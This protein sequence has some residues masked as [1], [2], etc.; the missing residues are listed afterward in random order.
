[1]HRTLVSLSKVLPRTAVPKQSVVASALPSLNRSRQPNVLD[2]LEQQKV[3][4]EAEGDLWPS[5]LRLEHFKDV[6]ASWNG[7]AAD[8]RQELKKVMRES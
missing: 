8:V 6:R 7:V 2:K 3:T 1:M 5:N 4:A